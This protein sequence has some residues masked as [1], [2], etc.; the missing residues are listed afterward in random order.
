MMDAVIVI[1]CSRHSYALG[2]KGVNIAAWGKWEM[3]NN[4][5]EKK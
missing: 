2:G 1:V 5:C 3:R 4:L